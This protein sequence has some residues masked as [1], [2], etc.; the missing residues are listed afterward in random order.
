MEND[1]Q[2]QL[3]LESGEAQDQD[4]STAYVKVSA[5]FEEHCQITAALSW[6]CAVLRRS[7][8]KGISFSSATILGNRSALAQIS[9]CPDVLEPIVTLN[10]CW[11]PLFQYAVIAR[12]FPIS[13][14]N[15]GRGLEISFSDMV[16]LSKSR[17]FF[18]VQG[19]LVLDGLVTLLYPVK[20]LSTDSAIQWHLELKVPNPSSDED[21]PGFVHPSEIMANS[22]IRE[23][24]KELDPEKLSNSRIFLG[25]A[26]EANVVLGTESSFALMVKNSGAFDSAP[27]RCVKTYGGTFGFGIHGIAS[28]SANVS[29]TRSAVPT[30]ISG[31]ESKE[32]DDVMLYLSNGIKNHIILYDDDKDTGWLIPQTTVFLFLVQI[33]LLRRPMGLK[34]LPS[35]MLSLPAH[36][37]GQ[38]AFET[39]SRFK[40]FSAHSNG[41]DYWAMVKETI[42]HLFYVSHDLRQIYTD[43]REAYEVAPELILGVE[44]VDVA[45]KEASMP[46]KSAKVSSPWAHLAEHQ[47]CVVLFC[48][49]LGQAIVSSCRDGLCSNWQSVPAGCKY[50]VSTGPSILHML[51][52]RTRKEVS[53]LADRI[54]WE[55]EHPIIRLHQPRNQIRCF[56]LQFLKSEVPGA[57]RKGLLQAVQACENGGFIF[58]NTSKIRKVMKC[59][60]ISA[61]GARIEVTVNFKLYKLL[62]Q[63]NSYRI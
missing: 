30:G 51:N 2:I 18:E 7:I 40:E 27:T 48:K 24:Y 33:F 9:L 15:E 59:R 4:I 26:S 39:L 60:P 50:L 6:F 46:V 42:H 11:S 49:D 37:G 23:W 35:E 1:I 56:H 55:F 31:I 52:K 34:F 36:D 21:S 12:G 62:I 25:W 63:A 19:G 16:S 14:R 61:K 45:L 47:P 53:R 43:A 29:G 41:D 10:S 13:P 38:A 22:V 28:I 58:T 17:A 3:D 57:D 20:I 5:T 32:N 54:T 8:H 44:L